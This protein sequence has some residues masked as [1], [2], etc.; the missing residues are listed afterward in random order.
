MLRQS[1]VLPEQ[2]AGP[3]WLHMVRMRVVVLLLLHFEDVSVVFPHNLQDL[4]VNLL[5]VGLRV[6]APLDR[7]VVIFRHVA[8]ACRHA[9]CWVE[10]RVILLERTELA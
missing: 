4:L 1:R 6:L 10:A 8:L 9:R 7:L 3:L 2:L 5:I